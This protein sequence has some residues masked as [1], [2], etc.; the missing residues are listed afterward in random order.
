ML[1]PFFWRLIIRACTA[2]GA[3]VLISVLVGAFYASSQTAPPLPDRMILSLTLDQ[4]FAE[5]EN[6]ALAGIPGFADKQPPTIRDVVDALERAADDPR[7][8]GLVAEMKGGPGNLAHLQELRAALGRFRTLHGKPAYIYASS[9]GEAGGLGAYYLASAFDQIWLQPM[10]TVSVSGL[11]AE[12]PFARDALDRLGIAPEFFARKEYKSIFES[13]TDREMSP[14]NRTATQALI[15]DLGTRMVAEI[16]QDR[17][18]SEMTVKTQ[19]DKGLLTDEEALAAGLVQ[20]VDYPDILKAEMMTD[21]ET[22]VSLSRYIHGLAHERKAAAKGKKD[23]P[24]TWVA[25]VY[26]VGAIVSDGDSGFY[27]EES[28]SAATI[29]EDILSAAEDDSIKAIILRID[30]PGGSPT[31]SETIRRAIV[32]AREE[33]NKPVIVSMGATAA[34]GGYWIA[35]PADRIFALPGSLTGSIGVAGG[36]VAL[37]GLWNKIGVNWDAVQYGDNTGLWSLNA[38]LSESGTER[39]NALMDRTY[40]GFIAR[41]AEG[42]HMSPEDVDNVARGRVWSGAQA[43]QRGL[44]D[45]LGGLSAALDYTAETLGVANRDDLAVVVLP[46]PLSPFEKITDLIEGQVRVGESLKVF[47][48]LLVPLQAVFEPSALTI[49][50]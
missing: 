10:G 46:R 8:V 19:L 25:L 23:D 38:P 40:E 29:S 6:D 37:T 42:R 45:A 41:V 3:M 49:K 1:L 36:K 43:Q 33:Y 24:R 13:L 27:G 48:G 28:A 31:A 50:P 11:R 18:L 9:Y 14:A 16:A 4:D 22:D 39:F 30:S 44:V 15:D 5:H 20:R 32:R 17:G 21:A 47:A 2:V 34:S 26:A 35:S 7:V 12:M